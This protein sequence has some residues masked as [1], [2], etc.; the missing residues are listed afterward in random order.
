MKR[1]EGKARLEQI[2]G[3]RDEAV[4]E[5]AALAMELAQEV[6]AAQSA[7][8]WKIEAV[9]ALV[10]LLLEE[11]ATALDERV[12]PSTRNRLSEAIT[13]GPEA[14]SRLGTDLEERRLQMREPEARL[15]ALRSRRRCLELRSLC[16]DHLA[17]VFETG[18]SQP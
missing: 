5:Y 3:D 2:D 17:T 15:R 4:R 16:L 8:S 7:S 1:A 10:S 18:R 11:T 14:L 9:E 6:T 12:S 13:C